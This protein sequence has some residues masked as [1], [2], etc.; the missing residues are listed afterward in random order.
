MTP[1]EPGTSTSTAGDTTVQ[2]EAERVII[3]T[4]DRELGITLSRATPSWQPRR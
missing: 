2:R 1:L 4:L 3:E